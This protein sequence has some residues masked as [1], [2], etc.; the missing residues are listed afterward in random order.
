MSRTKTFGKTYWGYSWV[1]TLENSVENKDNL[2]Y[3]AQIVYGSMIK[4]LTID[5]TVVKA[6]IIDKNKVSF[7]TQLSLKQF[8]KGQLEEIKDI[9]SSNPAIISEL[10]VGKLSRS[11]LSLLDSKGIN[12]LPT[13][14]DEVHAKCN[15]TEKQSPCTHIIAVYY[16]LSAEIDK[17]PF[18]LFN[19]KNL[20]VAHLSKLVG[21]SED[22]G[23]QSSNTLEDKLINPENVIYETLEMDIKPEDITIPENDI[24]Y[25]FSFLPERPIFYDRG[26]FKSLLYKIYKS[27]AEKNELTKPDQ[28]TYKSKN[29]DFYF[30][31]NQDNEFKAFVTPPYNYMYYLKS[32][33]SRHKN[34]TEYMDIPVVAD[35]KESLTTKFTEGLLLEADMVIEYFLKF[36]D[37]HADEGLSESFKYLNYTA[38]LAENL[39]QSLSFIPEVI[40]GEKTFFIRYVPFVWND[41]IRAK[42][43]KH[44][45]LM[46]QTLVFRQ[47]DQFVSPKEAAFDILSIFITYTVHKKV[48]LSARTSTNKILRAFLSPKPFYVYDFEEEN[49]GL[50]VSNWLEKLTLRKRDVVPIVR[51]EKEANNKFKVYVDLTNKKDALSATLPLSVLFHETNEIFGHPVNVV[52]TEISRQLIIS[53]DYLPVLKDILNAKGLQAP[54]IGLKEMTQIIIQSVGLM[55]LMGINVIIPKELKNIHVPKL[56]IRGKMKSGAAKISNISLSDLV[57][58]SYEIAIGDKTLTKEE[59]EALVENSEGIVKIKDSYV[60]LKPEDIKSI[61]KRLKDPI[62]PPTT[63]MELLHANY[64]GAFGDIEFISE[65]KLQNFI[66]EMYREKDVDI[67][68]ALK[69][70]LRPYQERGYRWLYSNFQ[71]GFGSCIADDMGL[72][73]TVQVIALLARL[74]EEKK[75]KHPAIVVCPTTLVG[76]WVKECQKFAPKLNVLIYYGTD[77][78][79]IKKNTDLV[80]TSYGTL[81]RDVDILKKETWSIVIVDEA[82]NI[83]NPDTEQ[84]RAVKDL[85]ATAYIAM[86]GTPVENR[87]AELWSIFDFTNKGYLGSLT[88]FYNQYAYAIERFRDIDASENLRNAISPFLLRRLKTDKT[89]IDD[90]PDKLVSDEYCYLSPEQAALYEKTVNNIMSSIQTTSGIN[91]KGNIFKL[92][93]SLKQICNHPKHYTK[94]GNDFS[95]LSGKAAKTISLVDKILEKEEKVLIFTQYREMGDILRT[96]MASELDE[97]PQFF[98]GSLS[99]KRRDEIVEE[100]QHNNDSKIMIISL[101]AGGTGLNLTAATNVIH[102]DLWWNPAVENQATD[103]TYRIGQDKKV[104]IYRLITLGTFEEKIDEIIKSKQELADL[105]VASGENWITELSDSEI[106]DLFRLT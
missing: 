4:N 1:Q 84:T 86:T 96:M 95:S 30:Y 76:N 93:T 72:G 61:L 102:Y 44:E 26:D 81:R 67:P 56:A 2:Y 50:N 32:Q 16:A 29:T 89:I 5:D 100:F 38:Q 54:V 21:F 20:S 3:G 78:Q 15:C 97:M 27:I 75:L 58:Y 55:S 43:H 59:F 31:F 17:N 106:K 66:K 70:E 63:T 41:E 85:S 10:I 45:L 6:T 19:L 74:K 101:K 8:N 39:V 18:I 82:Q 99:R 14:W 23:L 77:R 104:F 64:T 90:L 103:R 36:Q 88:N 53:S 52:R 62:K 69:A 24:D 12:I 105:T 49:I 87:L 48:V 35:D 91:R 65:N 92:I 60:Y 47:N 11:M 28:N 98:H 37:L 25:I 79:L 40:L 73:K 71:N 13:T 7:S 33:S 22:A 34:I 46:P 57:N 80:I 68:K 42:I 83:K 51:I 94:S 9:L